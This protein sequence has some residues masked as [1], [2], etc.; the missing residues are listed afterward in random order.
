MPKVTNQNPTMDDDFKQNIIKARSV[1]SAEL[2]KQGYNIDVRMLTTISV[3][4]TAALKFFKEEITGEEARQN[5]NDAIAM[6]QNN[7]VPF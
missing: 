4:T 6:Y 3:M 1:V 2:A 7:N 5:F